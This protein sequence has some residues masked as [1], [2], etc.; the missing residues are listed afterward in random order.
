MDL[1]TSLLCYLPPILHR[2]L[3]ATPSHWRDTAQELRL[4]I[5][6]PVCLSASNGDLSLEVV[7]DESVLADCFFRFCGQAIHAHTHELREGF[8][9][10]PEGFRVGVGGTAVLRDGAIY[11]YR[12]ITSLCVRLPRFIKGAATALMPFLMADNSGGLLLCGAPATG[13]TTVLR[14]AARQLSA[15]RRVAV[16]DE[17]S[18][19]ACEELARC[20]VLKG[21]PKA[22]GILQA[23]RSLAPDWIVADELG[24][25]E[26]WRA[27]ERSVHYGVPLLCSAHVGGE[28]EARRRPLLMQWLRRRAV[29]TVAFLPP[30]QTPT[31][32]TRLWKVED[33]LEN[34]R[35]RMFSVRLR[36]DGYCGDGALTTGAPFVGCV[37]DA[38]AT[39]VPRPAIFGDAAAIVARSGGSRGLDGAGVVVGI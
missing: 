1:W 32:P 11:T 6:Q 15:M 33:F 38:V 18:E 25:E 26:E 12:N 37:G 27:V 30:R 8:V 29:A 10:T 39:A 22:L 28:E 13:K 20:D 34:H 16:V 3:Q 14:D 31:E 9:T 17:R 36:G 7:A 35:D 23:V 5:G 21:C 2:A 19:L 24:D 4:R